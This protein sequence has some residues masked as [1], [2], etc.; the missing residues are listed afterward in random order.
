MVTKRVGL[1]ELDIEKHLSPETLGKI[2]GGNAQQLAE[3]IDRPDV[4]FLLAQAKERRRQLFDAVKYPDF[5]RQPPEK[6]PAVEPNMSPFSPLSP[7][8]P[9]AP[10][11]PA[12]PGAPGGMPVAAALR[13]F[14][15][16]KIANG[17]E[18]EEGEEHEEGEIESP[19]EESQ[20]S[21]PPEIMEQ[22]V[23]FISQQGQGI[24]DEGFHQ[25]AEGL[26]VEP[27][28]A[29]EGIYRLLASLVGGKN[30]VVSGGRAAGMPVE[31]FPEDQIAK[32]TD[33]ELEHTP[34]PA[35]ASEIA[36]DHLT[37]GADYYE[38][39]LE[40]LEKQMETDVDEGKINAIAKDTPTWNANKT[41]VDE[42][43][44][45]LKA[46]KK[47]SAFKHG[48]FLKIAE[49]GLKPSEF[50]EVFRLSFAKAAEGA[51]AVAG[52]LT[53][54]ALLGKIVD[55]LGGAAKGVGSM[56]MGAGKLGLVAPLLM[57][58]ILGG[59]AGGSA[60]YMTRPEELSPEDIKHMERLALYKRLSRRARRRTR[61]D[62]TEA[63]SEKT[64]GDDA[65]R[66]ILPMPTTPSVE[67]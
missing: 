56:A 20:E 58:P 16:M 57:A 30:D 7:G 1:R 35:I 65:H 62:E 12:E 59:V 22:L 19:E 21:L 4:Q 14:V 3:A 23:N 11:A 33:V 9:M 10:G 53:G 29:E 26:G 67:V 52:A 17:E 51:T 42:S 27:H 28:E 48:F 50:E 13:D 37:E 31:E 15:M 39:R 5:Y 40:N 63:E 38:P 61:K 32:G 64:R 66:N 36:K 6:R 47:K 43:R 2:M 54:G 49:E 18:M 46:S 34:N 8:S 45:D 55:L 41:E 60:Y 44:D 24:D 25:Q